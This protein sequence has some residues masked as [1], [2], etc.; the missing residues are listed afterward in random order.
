MEDIW[1][2]I[3]KD[4]NTVRFEQAEFF[5]PYCESVIGSILPSEDG[6]DRIRI[7]A[8]YRYDRIFQQLLEEQEERAEDGDK[9]QPERTRAL[10]YDY[11]MHLLVRLEVRNG[12]TQKELRIRSR[13]KQL[14]DGRYGERVQSSFR[15]FEPELK[16]K[17]AFYLVQQEQTG[18]SVAL[19]GKVLTD[20]LSDGVLYK[21]DINDKEL[22][23][24]LGRKKRPS[25]AGLIAAVEELFLPFLYTLR[26]FYETP[27]GVIE[28]QHCM[29]INEI[30][31]F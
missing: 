9:P 17:T 19:F 21:H 5:S 11:L 20:L 7:N 6:T 12:V 13:L 29:N 8:F 23:F 26:V 14:E 16:Y 25:D 31:I 28:N 22:L 4:L 2:R 10:L 27:F 18:E 1:K 15:E 30:E 3:M 24:Y